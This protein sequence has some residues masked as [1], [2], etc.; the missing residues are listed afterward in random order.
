VLHLRGAISMARYEPGSATG[1]FSIMLQPQ[2]GL[3]ADPASDDPDRREGYAAFGYV[4]A[5]MDVVEAIHAAPVDPEL[6]EGWMKG[7]M[8]AEPVAILRAH[9]LPG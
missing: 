5:G 8:L 6:G 9:R 2:S 1:D 4:T 3:D 7:Q